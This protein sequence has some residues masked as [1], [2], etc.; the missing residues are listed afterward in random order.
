MKEKRWFIIN[1]R[2]EIIS[3]F[4][5]T[6]EDAMKTWENL[7]GERYICETVYG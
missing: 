1:Q 6:Y 5:A 3:K 4:F 7:C 2:N